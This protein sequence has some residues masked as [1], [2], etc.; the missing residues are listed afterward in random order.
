MRLPILYALSYPYRVN[1]NTKRL[2]F[3]ELGSLEFYKPDLK[4]FPCLRIAYE[5][6]EKGGNLACAMN[7]ANE[8]AVQSFLSGNIPF[9]SI[10]KIIEDVISGTEFVADPSIADIYKTDNKARELASIIKQN[11]LNGYII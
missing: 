5:V 4:K 9:N 10:P 8:I 11:Y 7:A 1:L 3:A 6:I 2:N